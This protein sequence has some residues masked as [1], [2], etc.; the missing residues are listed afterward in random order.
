LANKLVT[1]VL[2]LEREGVYTLKNMLL[3]N[4]VY[5]QVPHA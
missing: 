5:K 4:M 1:R 2:L 3:N